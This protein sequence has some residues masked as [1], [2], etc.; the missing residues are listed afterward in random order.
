MDR[1]KL[2]TIHFKEDL[3]HWCAANDWPKE[4][5]K[6][7]QNGDNPYRPNKDGLSPMHAAIAH[8]A[9]SVVKILLERY[10]SDVAIVKD[11][12]QNRF[13]WKAENNCWN[14]RPI[15]IACTQEERDQVH[16]LAS[17][18]PSG[19]P[20]NVQVFVLFQTPYNGTQ[21]VALDV[22]GSAE[23]QFAV[24][25]CINKLLPNGVLSL[26]RTD[27]RK[28]CFTYLQTACLHSRQALI[29][30]LIA[31]GSQ[32]SA[33]GDRETIPLMTACRTVK[34]P[35][36]EQL[37]TKYV[38]RYDPTVLDSQQRNV[39]HICLELNNHKLIDYVLKSLIKYRQAQFGETESE[40]FNRI[41]PYKCEEYSY[42]TTWSLIRPNA[43]E[44]CSKYVVDYRLDLS[45]SDG[46]F[47]HVMEL[48]QKKVALEYCFEEI[49][50]NPAILKLNKKQDH[51]QNVLHQLYRYDHLDF[52]K[53]MYEQ[54]P[55]VKPW[56]ETKEA[57]VILRIT[58]THRDIQKL[59]LIL[60]HHTAY[61]SSNPAELEEF[62]IGQTWFDRAVYR[63]PFA[64]LAAAFPEKQDVMK[65]TMSR[66]AELQRSQS[67]TDRFNA[68]K[69]AFNL[70]LESLKEDHILLPSLL[71]D[72][73]RNVLHQ[74]I[75]WDEIE[76]IK[77][78]LA[79]GIDLNQ[80]DGEGN[81]P[82]FFV[83]S[84]A[85][86]DILYEKMSV[87]L[88]TTNDKG[89]NLLHHC[90]RVGS[91]N[92]E[93]I[94]T[95][96][97]QLGFDINQ[98]SL[99]GN[100]PLSIATC[101]SSVRFLLSN[102]A[103]VELVNGEALVKTLSGK[104]YCAAWALL[105]KIAHLSWFKEIAHAFLPWMLGN[106]NRDFFSCSS[107]H[108]LEEYPD[109]R[110]TLFDSLYRHSQHEAAAF[111]LKVCHRSINC[112]ARW[113][114]DYGYEIDLEVRDDYG[115]TPL[116]GLLSYMEEPNLDVI[117]RL[118]QKG[119]NVNARDDR[120]RNS[121]L[122]LVFNFRSAQWNGHTLKSIELLLDHGAEINVQDEDGNSALHLAFADMHLD[123]AQLLLSR[124][125]N[126]KL[127]NK[128]NKLP[129]QMMVKN[130][131][132]LLAF[133]G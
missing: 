87:D 129:H 122:T 131:Q 125:A 104:L 77:N 15:L 123:M 124:G 85:A 65:E 9:T 118:L 3:L 105:L 120:G 97:L 84:I 37:L 82:I 86:F 100:V 93:A 110:K 132:A 106:Q 34:L 67:F 6:R 127:K 128:A 26:D 50:R 20:F 98:R 27:L 91:H 40:A 36:V 119:A 66:A 42:M 25:E 38:N 79:C 56:F 71:D 51:E 111:F 41:F 33:T 62:A 5:H 1:R 29:P 76:M 114:L 31:H 115:Y 23:K 83:R 72:R 73:K 10:E 53:E 121:L 61:L 17:S 80:R 57:F 88:K 74:A 54:H 59:K 95:K 45:Y 89:Y 8:N 14:K 102:G 39:F 7:L 112:C 68:L 78:L 52:V 35:I 69:K 94:L 13:L 92:G 19:I 24:L 107:G 30:L 133:L 130:M 18:C 109:I 47:L 11:H 22:N 46:D 101:C 21:L 12:M 70:A 32:L 113:F 103:N 16:L 63:E 126:R 44:L 96:L 58:L 64:L 108:Y 60:E 116:L 55:E 2:N 117:E 90:S 99:D 48:L 43:K 49:R 4:V 28:D 75:E 81:L